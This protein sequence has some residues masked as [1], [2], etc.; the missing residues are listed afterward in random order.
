[1]DADK[2]TT[3]IANKADTDT[4]NSSYHNEIPELHHCETQQSTKNPQQSFDLA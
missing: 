4:N 3:V 2:A 1:M